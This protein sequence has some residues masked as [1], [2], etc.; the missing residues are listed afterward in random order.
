MALMRMRQAVM[1][2]LD[3]ALAEDQTVIVM[4]E[5]IAAAGGPFKVTEGL[6]EKHGPDRVIDTPISEM[7]FMDD[8]YATMLGTR[9]LPCLASTTD[10]ISAGTTRDRMRG[11]PCAERRIL[12][13]LAQYGSTLSW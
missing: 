7:G 1:K 13:Q 12:D 5:D 4:G 6:L 3:D 10:A 9:S 11:T 2:A 8:V